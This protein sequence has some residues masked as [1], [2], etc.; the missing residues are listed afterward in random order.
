[1][2]PE[3]EER[4]AKIQGIID[5]TQ[6]VADQTNLLRLDA[7]TE[8]AR[9][10]EVGRGSVVLADEVRTLAIRVAEPQS[11]ISFVVHGNNEMI[12]DMHHRMAR[13]SELS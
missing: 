11:E 5:T 6:S 4:D 12:V 3:R 10:G 8:A 2:A 13:V 9:G 7:A 1:M